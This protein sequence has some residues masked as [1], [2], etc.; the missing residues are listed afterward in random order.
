MIPVNRKISIDEKE[1]RLEFIQASGPGG[2]NV[3]KVATAV[4]LRFDVDRSASLPQAVR[5]RLAKIA[6]NRI[7]EKGE[8]VIKAARY[9]TQLQNRRDALSRLMALI[10]AAAVKPKIRK[11]TRPSAASRKRILESKRRRGRLKQMRQ[12]VSAG[13]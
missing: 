2:Q 5:E 11:K 13:D 10:R 1:I 3:N 12:R 9:R 4:L 8:L 6:G 7:T